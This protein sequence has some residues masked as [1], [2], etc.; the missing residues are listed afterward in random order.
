MRAI[1]SA[2]QH[3][4]FICH[5]SEDKDTIVRE[6]AGALRDQHLDVWYDEFSLKVGDSLRQTIGVVIIS[7]AFFAKR[8]PIPIISDV[9]GFQSLLCDLCV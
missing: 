2:L 3:D 9:P 5:A 4:V 8:W 7:P 6:L 1:S